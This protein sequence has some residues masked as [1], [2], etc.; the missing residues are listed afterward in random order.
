MSS[1]TK[2]VEVLLDQIAQERKEINRHKGDVVASVLRIAQ[3]LT[4]LHPLGRAA[5]RLG[6][7]N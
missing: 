5:N 1:D 7:L 6:R 2:G 3:H 4:E